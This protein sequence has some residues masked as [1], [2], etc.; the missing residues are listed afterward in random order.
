MSKNKPSNVLVWLDQGPYAYINL[1]IAKSLS[2]FKHFNFFGIVTTNQD[3]SF[4]NNQ[5]ITPFNEIIYYPDCYINKFSYDIDYLK[6]IEKEFDLN[7]WLDVYSERFFHKHRTDFH[8]FSK[9]EIL[10]IVENSIIFFSELLNRINPQLI[11]MQTAGENIANALLFKIAKKLKIKTLMI[12]PTHI[13][14][15][16]VISDNLTSQEI[17]NEFKQIIENFDQKLQNYGPDFIKDQSLGETVKV[18]RKFNFDNASTT[19]K[20]S[21]YINRL[22]NDPEPIYQNIGKTKSKMLK[23]K[24]STNIETKKRKAFLDKNSIFEIEDE[25]FLYFPLHTEP[26]AKI[27]ATSPFFS[28]QLSVVENIARSIPIDFTLYVKEHPGQEMKLWRSIDYYR[29][30]IELPNVKLVHPTVNSQKLIS[31]CSCVVSITG[32]TGFEAL[33]YKKP[34]ILFADEYYDC[35]SMVNKIN[36]LTDLPS[37]ISK[38]MNSFEFNNKELNALIFSSDS[39]SL[40]LPYFQI[41]RDALTVSSLQR[42]EKNFKSTEKKF[43]D[44]YRNYNKDFELLGNEFNKKFLN[45]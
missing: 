30:I 40:Q 6:K 43:N 27:L 15:R 28:N 13:H 1:G 26:E 23:S 7:L 34:V 24:L 2:K 41:M 16:V 9:S 18:Q 22:S 31:K 39:Q 33:F 11:I 42:L 19:Q 37:L 35:L 5:K 14:N 25:K 20:L 44:F 3:V 12:N 45:E 38:T 21:H 10:I 4:F 36:N 8:K 29:K 32:S 17:S